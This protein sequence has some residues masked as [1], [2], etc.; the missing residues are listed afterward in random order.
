MHWPI[1]WLPCARGPLACCQV[2]P[3]SSQHV[4]LPCCMARQAELARTKCAVATAEEH[5]AK[6][7]RSNQEMM[8]VLQ[9]R[10]WLAYHHTYHA[11]LS[12]MKICTKGWRGRATRSC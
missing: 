8:Q 1:S 11:N 2:W 7:L 10:G 4:S 5:V 6:M 12:L 9:V 3:Q